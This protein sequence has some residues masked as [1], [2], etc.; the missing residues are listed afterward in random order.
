M[1]YKWVRSLNQ[2]NQTCLNLQHQQTLFTYI[3]RCRSCH[4]IH[5]KFKKKQKVTFN[6]NLVFNL[7]RN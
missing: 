5:C 2:L 7:R 3:I 1:K 4:F 6:N